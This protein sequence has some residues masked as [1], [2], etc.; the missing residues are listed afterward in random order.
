MVKEAIL[1]SPCRCSQYDMRCTGTN[2][3]HLL[4]ESTRLQRQRCSSP[5]RTCSTRSAVQGIEALC[6]TSPPV[7]TLH[8]SHCASIH[9]A[10]SVCNARSDAARGKR[11]VQVLSVLAALSEPVGPTPLVQDFTG[12]CASSHRVSQPICVPPH[13]VH[14]RSQCGS[15]YPFPR[16]A[17]ITHQSKLVHVWTTSEQ[18]QGLEFPRPL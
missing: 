17:Q 5:G 10:C 2:I 7:S 16:T 3:I 1:C 4:Q 9:L 12:G 15:P 11:S 13:L 18:D 6:I 8:F 14:R